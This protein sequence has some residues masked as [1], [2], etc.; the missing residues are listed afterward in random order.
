VNGAGR[1]GSLYTVVNVRPLV[2]ISAALLSSF[3]FGQIKPE[4]QSIQQS[5]ENFRAHPGLQITQN[6]SITVG[7]TTST[8]TSLTTWFQDVE[9]GRPMAKVE[10]IVRLN[11]AEIFR[12]EGDGTTLY[13]YDEQR[14]EYSSTRYGNYSG[15]QPTEY[16]NTLLSAVRSMLQGPTMYP[17][18]L[19]SEV[20]GGSDARYT[21]WLPGAAIE[22]TGTVVRYTL[23]SPVHRSMEF[24]YTNMPPNVVLNSITYFDHTDMPNTTRD[25]NWSMTFTSSDVILSDITFSFIPPAG[26]RPVVG[27]RPVTGG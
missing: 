11:G 27:V 12:A 13:E 17:G 14:N 23:G 20:Y 15:A 21:T 7:T 25:V 2:L 16:V 1:M 3:A 5:F 9:D 26:A 10:I 4:E 18:R 8:F 6:G 22:N 24:S 19:I